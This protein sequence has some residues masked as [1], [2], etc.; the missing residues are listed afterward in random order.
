MFQD[1]NQFAHAPG[2]INELRVHEAPDR[3]AEV[4]VG[5]IEHYQ[6]Q[7]EVG[8]GESNEADKGQAVISPTVL[9]GRRIDS[10]WKGNKP[11]EDDGDD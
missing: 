11:G 1:R 2:L 6:R 3:G 8:C 5:E 4:H 9:V 10:N 7:Q